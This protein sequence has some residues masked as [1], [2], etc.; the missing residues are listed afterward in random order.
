LSGWLQWN[1]WQRVGELVL[2]VGVGSLV[3]FG[4]LFVMGVNVGALMG[5]KSG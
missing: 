2:W 3:Y 5:R 1:L 4:G